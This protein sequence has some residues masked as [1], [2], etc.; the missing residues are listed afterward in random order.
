V[1]IFLHRGLGEQELTGVADVWPNLD[2]VLDVVYNRDL[3]YGL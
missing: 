1:S 3:I 2:S